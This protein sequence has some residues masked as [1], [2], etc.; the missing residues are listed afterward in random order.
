[1]DILNPIT[2]FIFGI[3]AAA[4]WAVL[5]LKK[6]FRRQPHVQLRKRHKAV[7]ALL[8]ALAFAPSL[9][10]AFILSFPIGHLILRP[11]PAAHLI[12]SLNIA[13]C[14]S[15]IGAALTYLAALVSLF[16]VSHFVRSAP[17]AT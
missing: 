10:V 7:P 4:Y 17:A 2:A 9:Y 6:A 1:M 5:F 15:I 3:L 12:M 11:G 16:L 8:A 13:L 14:L